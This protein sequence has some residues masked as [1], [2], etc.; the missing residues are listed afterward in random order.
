MEG[1]NEEQVV[2]AKPS[3]FQ[4]RSSPPAPKRKLNQKSVFIAVLIFAFCLAGTFI[5]AFSGSVRPPKVLQQG[6]ALATTST[7]VN[8]LPANYAEYARRQ[9]KPEVKQVAY[10]GGEAQ[11]AESGVDKYLEELRQAR[12]KRAKLARESDLT[13]KEVRLERRSQVDRGIGSAADGSQGGVG[14]A[15][16]LNPRE[17]A[18]R[19]DEK[20]AFLDN[21]RNVQTTLR[22]TLE[23]PLSPYQVMAGSI[24][25]GILLSGINSDLPGQI[26]GQ[27]SQPVFDSV[28]GQHLLLPQGTKVIG[29]YDSAIVYGQERV[30]IVWTR[31]ILPNGNSLSLEGMP[32]I[33]L[34]GYAGLKDRANNHYGRLLTG[35]V[36][37]SILGAGVQM[38]EGSKDSIDPSFSQL[39]AEGA[40]RNI[41]N[42]GQQ[43]TRKNLNIQ[44]TIEIRQGMRFSVFVT[45]DL[46]LEP[47]Q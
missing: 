45:K 4:F 2:E 26:V 6:Q 31:L 40:A 34:S 11:A 9:K 41:N 36:L 27:V 23:A 25:P 8:E 32:G 44:P 42:A 17:D 13:F 24:I 19:Q 7:L 5:F 28:S 46:I 30:L 3:Q 29:T 37:G 18:S 47:Y 20:R 15:A 10:Q 12:L 14:E 33:D 22:Q 35:V 16:G 1:S 38:A 43:I 39:A 21:P